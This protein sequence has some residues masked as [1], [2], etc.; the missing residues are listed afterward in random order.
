VTNELQCEIDSHLTQINSFLERTVSL[1][2][3]G[4]QGKKFPMGLEFNERELKGLDN[5]LTL[6]AAKLLKQHDINEDIW[7]P[8][9]KYAFRYGYGKNEWSWLESFHQSLSSSKTF[10]FSYMTKDKLSTIFNVTVRG[11]SGFIIGDENNIV[12]NKGFSAQEMFKLAEELKMLRVEMKLH[13]NTLEADIAVGSV[14]KAELAAKNGDKSGVLIHLKEAGK[15]A[16]D[17]A[18]KIGVSVAAKAI[19]QLVK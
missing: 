3:L 19:E 17:V 15:W 14:A 5:S 2:T 12:F 16:F 9:V 7:M 10:F 4:K 6:L 11:S 8:P 18:T 13:S 1:L